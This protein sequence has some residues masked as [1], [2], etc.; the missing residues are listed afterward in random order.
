MKVGFER[1]KSASGVDKLSAEK[2]NIYIENRKSSNFPR[3]RDA[4][5]RLVLFLAGI[6]TRRTEKRSFC[7]L[8]AYGLPNFKNANLKNANF[9][10][11]N[12]GRTNSENSA[13]CRLTANF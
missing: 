10:R 3:R 8:P 5:P 11:A 1:K 12:P 6:T 9:K 4:R 13:I 2:Y 7:F